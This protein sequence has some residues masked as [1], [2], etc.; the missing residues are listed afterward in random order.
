VLAI[1]RLRSAAVLA[2]LLAAESAEA[3][4]T[5]T[6]AYREVGTFASLLVEGDP[7]GQSQVDQITSDEL[8]PFDET[9]ATQLNEEETFV[10]STASLVSELD[11]DA[12]T[13]EGVFDSHAGLGPTGIF[14]EGFGAS[15]AIVHLHVSTPTVVHAAGTLVASGNGSSHVQLRNDSQTY[16]LNE[17]GMNGTFPLL[18][19]LSLQPGDYILQVTS[20]GYGRQ[21]DGQPPSPAAGSFDLI[22]SFGGSTS[23]ATA[24]ASSRADVMVR[25][26]PI[27]DA[28]VIEL[29][30][31]VTR[32]TVIAVFDLGGRRVRDL[33]RATTG[34]IAWDARDDQGTRLPAGVYFV[35]AG[36]ASARAIVVR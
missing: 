33:G 10:S 13:M 32:G 25:P 29:G 12:I 14:A 35:R 28:A 24:I 20:G 22:L 34:T 8:G 18:A 21:F 36:L 26:N 6:S 16:F 23:A 11:L 2:I 19:D 15:I 9:I 27:R 31:S 7:Q 5:V 17:G 3:S 1:P 4:V 30:P